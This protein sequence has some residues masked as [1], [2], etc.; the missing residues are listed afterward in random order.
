MEKKWTICVEDGEVT[1]GKLGS[2]KGTIQWDEQYEDARITMEENCTHGCYAITCG[3][4]GW[5]VHTAYFSKYPDAIMAYKRMKEE[6]EHLC[7]V[8]DT[9]KTEEIGIFINRW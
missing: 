4:S 1:V 9:N 2:E 3:I 6:I 8:D 5:F 7:N